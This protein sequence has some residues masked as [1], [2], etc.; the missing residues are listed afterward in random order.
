MSKVLATKLANR[1]GPLGPRPSI[2]W[3]RGPEK[4]PKSATQKWVVFSFLADFYGLAVEFIYE[5]TIMAYKDNCAA[6]TLQG[7]F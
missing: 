4:G 6:I 5:V 3:A 7:V 2:L 1:S